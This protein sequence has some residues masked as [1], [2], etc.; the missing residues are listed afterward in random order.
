MRGLPDTDPTMPPPAADLAGREYSAAPV[1]APISAAIEWPERE[2]ENNQIS[3]D[4]LEP[5]WAYY[6]PQTTDQ[7]ITDDTIARGDDDELER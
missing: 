5:D 7:E 1:A 4:G 3:G 6:R 2:P